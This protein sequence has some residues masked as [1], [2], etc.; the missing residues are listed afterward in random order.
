MV[1]ISSSV[2]TISLG[3][4]TGPFPVMSSV[5]CHPNAQGGWRNTGFPSPSCRWHLHPYFRF[6]RRD[7][8]SINSE[9]PGAE[10]PP[11]SLTSCSRSWPSEQD[12]TLMISFCR[13]PVP[14]PG[15]LEQERR[16]GPPRLSPGEKCISEV[17]GVGMWT[18]GPDK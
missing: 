13:M 15:H 9:Q 5:S 2:Q 14:G 6:H 17:I 8:V 3:V 16:A 1:S 18:A 4:D 12:K 10:G 7:S 11:N